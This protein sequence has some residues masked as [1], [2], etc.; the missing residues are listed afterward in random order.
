MRPVQNLYGD[1]SCLAIANSTWFLSDYLFTLSQRSDYALVIYN[2]C[3]ANHGKERDEGWTP[4]L[5]AR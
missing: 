3:G 1:E 4:D 2:F 5:V